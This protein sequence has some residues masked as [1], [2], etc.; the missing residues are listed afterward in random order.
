MKLAEKKTIPTLDSKFSWKLEVVKELAQ[1]LNFAAYSQWL[2]SWLVSL[3]LVSEVGDS[4][5][6]PVIYIRCK[7]RPGVVA[8]F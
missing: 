7:Y 6:G 8:W 5:R 2:C 3:G 4:E 1:R